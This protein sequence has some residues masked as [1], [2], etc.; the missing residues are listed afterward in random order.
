MYETRY[1]QF[2]CSFFPYIF[3]PDLPVICI[4][5]MYNIAAGTAEQRKAVLD[6]G[7]VASLITLLSVIQPTVTTSASVDLLQRTVCF[8]SKLCFFKDPPLELDVI[9]QIFAV[10]KPLLELNDDEIRG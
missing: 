9:T 8:L 6:A 10:L 7:I 3:S 4:K 5:I 2:C 1:K